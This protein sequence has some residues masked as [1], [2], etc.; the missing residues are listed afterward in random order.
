MTNIEKNTLD[1][2]P[3]NHRYTFF[4]GIFIALIASVPSIVL[5][6]PV[7][8]GAKIW[9]ERY[10]KVALAKSRVKIAA[11]D[12]L[13]SKKIVFSI[14]AVPV[15]WITYAVLLYFFSGLEVRTIVMLFLACPLFSYIA[16]RS[17]EA[18]MVDLKDLRPAFLRL[19][20]SFRVEAK[21]IPEV[22]MRLQKQVRAMV[23]KYV[24]YAWAI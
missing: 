5:N 2:P 4:H 24:N 6:M 8:L 9:A 13:L 15:L 19:L 7:G 10:Q 3:H 12:V 14:A 21:K 20:P 23:R 17:I 11:T 18:G 1:P 22:R 16:I